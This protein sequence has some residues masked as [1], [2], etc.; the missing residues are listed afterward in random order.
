MKLFCGFQNKQDF[1]INKRMAISLKQVC[2]K[3]IQASFYNNRGDCFLTQGSLMTT[4]DLI[5][6]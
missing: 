4:E 1:K 2:C 3:F 6:H 5:Q